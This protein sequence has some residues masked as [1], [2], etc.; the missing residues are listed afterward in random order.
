[1]RVVK[2]AILCT[3]ALASTSACSSEPTGNPNIV[4]FVAIQ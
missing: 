3:V 4:R 2:A 1:M